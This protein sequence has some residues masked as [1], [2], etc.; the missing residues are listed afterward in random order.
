MEALI[1]TAVGLLGAEAEVAAVVL[2]PAENDLAPVALTLLT[3][4]A[5]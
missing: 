3:P 5:A 4:T 2:P 1:L